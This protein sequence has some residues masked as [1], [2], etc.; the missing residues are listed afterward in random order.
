MSEP[1]LSICIPHLDRSEHLQHA[2]DSA[3]RQT[4]P[5]NVVVADQGHTERTKAVMDR[6]AD[7]PHVRHV[8]TESTCLWENWKAAAEAADT[9]FVGWLQDDDIVSRVYASRVIQAF[10]RFPQALHWQARCYVSPDRMHAVWWGVNGP[11]VGLDMINLQPEMWP[12]GML[13]ASMFLVSWALSPGVAFRVGDEFRLALDA[14]PKRCDLFAERLILAAMGAQGPWVA[15]PVVAGYWHHHGKNES[16]AQNADGSIVAQQ[17]LMCEGLDEIIDHSPEWQG[18]FFRWL[19]MRSPVEILGWLENFR[20]KESRHAAEV[21][22]VM[23]ESIKDRVE[24]V[25]GPEPAV[26]EP[27]II[28]EDAA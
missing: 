12:G 17:K 3:L 13:I 5:V 14:M 9:E 25:P 2:I 23:T 26:G 4:M 11:Q 21:K 22:A 20:C 19:R 15:D 16:Y 27:T 28:Y 7:H 1:R 8:L 10:D 6:Y 18:H 24:A